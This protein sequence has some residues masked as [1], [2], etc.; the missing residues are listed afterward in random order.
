VV[1]HEDI[2]ENKYWRTGVLLKNKMLNT[3]ALIK[4]DYVEHLIIIQVSG[5]NSRQYFGTIRRILSNIEATLT[6]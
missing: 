2:I 4:V 1:L 6:N 5:K 3:S